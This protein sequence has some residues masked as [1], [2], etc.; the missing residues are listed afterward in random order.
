MI[1][2]TAKLGLGLVLFS[3]ILAG[4]STAAKKDEQPKPVDVGTRGVQFPVEAMPEPVVEVIPTTFYFDFDQS[5]LKD[6]TKFLLRRHAEKLSREPAAIILEGHADE[7]GT[8]EYNLAL[9]ERRAMAVRD[10]LL[11]LDV[12]V[13]IEVISYGE[14]RPAVIG[15][16]GEEGWMLNRRVELKLK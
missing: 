4:C 3:V 13:D 5:E 1:K 6:K 9:G 2:T 11:A 12:K 7:R 14:E 15:A 8:R 10:F 16:N